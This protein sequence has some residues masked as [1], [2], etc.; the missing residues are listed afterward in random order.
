MG[1]PVLADRSGPPYNAG[2][3]DDEAFLAAVAAH[4]A[5]DTPRLVYADW[6]DDRGDPRAEYVRLE[7]ER[8]RLKPRDKDRRAELTGRL[9]ALRPLAD[10]HWLPR[11]DRV[12]RFTEYWSRHDCRLM[13]EQGLVGTPF[14][15]SRVPPQKVAQPG[16]YIYPLNYAEGVLYVVA[17]GRYTR[18]DRPTRWEVRPEIGEG[19]PL[20]FDRAVPPAALAR[21]GWYGGREERRAELTEDGQGLAWR[22]ANNIC[23]NYTLRLTPATAADLDALLRAG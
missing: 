11:I 20:A 19:A 2:M 7:A 21:F 5:D 14:V 9:E 13:R 15:Q 22:S 4:P 3:S 16:D 6:L 23:S 10:P 8:H 12:R 1:L 18:I 17:R